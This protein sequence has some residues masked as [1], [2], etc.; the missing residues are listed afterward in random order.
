MTIFVFSK[1]NH[2]GKILLNGRE[3]VSSQEE[4]I[5][6]ATAI[7]LAAEYR[8][9]NLHL[10]LLS[11][12]DTRNELIQKAHARGNIS[13]LHVASNNVDPLSTKYVIYAIL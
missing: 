3:Y 10:I 2:A 8:S 12:K 1:G 6:E 13:P 11:L 4:W 5:F 7:H 9:R